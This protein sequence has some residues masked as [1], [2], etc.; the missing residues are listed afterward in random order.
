[1]LHQTHDLKGYKLGARD[2]EIGKVTEFYFD[3]RNWTV[4][5]LVADTGDWLVGRRVLLSP[6]ALDP[7]KKDLEIIPVD[8]TKSQ[9]ENSPSLEMEQ[10]VSRQYEMQYYPYYGWPAYWEGPFAWGA[11]EIPYRGEATWT[12][13]PPTTGNENPNLRSTSEVAGYSIHAADGELGHVDDFILDDE[14]W[15]IRYLIVDTR[16]W[17]PGKKVLVST[18]WIERISWED[19]A[20][21]V[22][23][24]RDT[25]KRAPEYN[26]SRLLNREY[27]ARLHEHYDREG[28]WVV[29]QLAARAGR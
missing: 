13:P 19:S 23:L 10:P 29:A 8:L 6:Y 25:I 27:E 11:S 4:R 24:R 3:D 26:E 2:G 9:I 22:N 15:M 12:Q 17:W 1:M 20:V 5:Y 7:V 28:Y 18:G 14:N 21:F 16:N